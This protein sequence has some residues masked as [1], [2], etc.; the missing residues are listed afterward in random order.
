MIDEYLSRITRKE[1]MNV[2]GGE[3]VKEGYYEEGKE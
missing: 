1:G 2:Y 3:G